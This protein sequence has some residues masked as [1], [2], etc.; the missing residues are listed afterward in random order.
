MSKILVVAEKPSV[1]RDIAR[2]LGCK[3]RGPGCIMNDEYVITWAIG[4]LVALASPEELDDAYKV[5]SF[6]TLPIIPKEMKVK[7]IPRV[8]KQYELVSEWMNSPEIDSIVCAT[9][10]GREGELIF[11]LIYNMAECTKPY[12]RLWISS[13]TDEAISEGFRNLRPGSEYDNLYASARCRSEADWLVGMNASRGFTLTYDTLLSVGRVQSPTLAILVKRERERQNFVPQIYWELWATFGKYKG[14]W[15]DPEKPASEHPS[16]IT[17]ERLEEMTAFAN[18]AK[19]KMGE[20]TS[21]EKTQQVTKPPLLYDLTTLQRDANRVFGWPAV[22]TL[23]IAQN[24]YEKRKVITYPRT[25]SRYLSHDLIKTLKSRLSKLKNPA[26][27]PFIPLAMESQRSLGGRVINDARVSDHHAIIPTGKSV[28]MKKWGEEEA[29]LYDMVVRRYISIFLDDEIAELVK[30]VTK[31]EKHS[32]LSQG[33]TVLQKGWT[34]IYEGMTASK[35]KKP[36]E[37]PLPELAVGDVKKVTSV[38]LTEKKTQP[39]SPY[40]EAMLLGAMENA[41]RTIEDEELRE[42]MKDSGLG[43]PATRASIIERLIQVGYV[44]RRGKILTPTEKGMIFVQ[45]LPEPMISAETTGRWEKGLA[46]I[47][48]GEMDPDRFM[49]DICDFVVEI[50]EE[51]RHKKPDITFPQTGHSLTAGAAKEPLGVCPMCGGKVLENSK[52]FYCDQWRS[53]CHLTMWKNGMVK[54]GGP[55]LDAEMVKTLL[56][57]KT[58]KLENGM[59]ELVRG[60]PYAQWRALGPDGEYLP[61]AQPEEEAAPA[62]KKRRKKA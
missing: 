35:R 23:R 2:V 28:D 11:R 49:K 45:V 27:D 5:W 53:G 4:H 21:V 7:V 39:P 43:T 46:Q 60:K 42:E 14:C 18:E 13:M 54:E 58:L 52:A 32:F 31:V 10:S 61:P 12:K 34:A 55:M 29:A 51:S 47:G 19:G 44:R 17:E 38:K 36:E 57:E 22:K 25:D 30:V 3:T 16:R 56:E 33:R 8:R 1:G 41:G 50:V 24:L 40:T 15:F 20:V 48:R 37:K 59:I 9:D 62:P 26:W 6:D